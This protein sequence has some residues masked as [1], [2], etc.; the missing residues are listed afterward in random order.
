[1]PRKG[2]NPTA[3]LTGTELRAAIAEHPEAGALRSAIAEHVP[4]FQKRTQKNT[5]PVEERGEKP[6]SR[7]FCFTRQ[8]HG[9][10]RT[11]SLF[12]RAG[13]EFPVA[14]DHACCARDFL[15]RAKKSKWCRTTPKH[16]R[17]GREDVCENT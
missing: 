14:A 12:S 1:M 9:V 17:P 5:A 11:N 10:A 3:A 16:P 6:I 15:R 7:S 13:R 8:L 4:A 2:P